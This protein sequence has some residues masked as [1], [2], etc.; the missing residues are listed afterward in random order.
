MRKSKLKNV[1]EV[2]RFIHQQVRSIANLDSDI[3]LND[4]LFYLGFDS[5][6]SIILSTKLNEEFKIDLPV[7]FLIENCTIEEMSKYIYDLM[8]K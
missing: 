3:K 6:N 7:S 8:R 5:I 2:Q 4:N 1:D